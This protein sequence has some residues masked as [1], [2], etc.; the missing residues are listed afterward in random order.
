MELAVDKERVKEFYS[1]RSE[2]E[3][4]LV[5]VVRG[6]IEKQEGGVISDFFYNHPDIQ[7][8]KDCKPEV[9]RFI[10][11]KYFTNLLLTYRALGGYPVTVTMFGLTNEGTFLDWLKIFSSD[12]IGFIHVANVYP[13]ILGGE[14]ICR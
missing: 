9:Q 13:T 5:T 6:L 4:D 7:S 1:P 2:T 3:V 12:T 10:L 8:I 14:Y 11:N